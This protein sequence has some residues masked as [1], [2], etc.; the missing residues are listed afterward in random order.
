MPSLISPVGRLQSRARQLLGMAGPRIAC[1]ATRSGGLIS[2]MSQLPEPTQSSISTRDC[3][4]PNSKSMI[5]FT[6]RS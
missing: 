1:Q 2:L 4:P 6:E 5:G 3:A